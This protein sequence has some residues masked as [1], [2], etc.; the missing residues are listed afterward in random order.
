[1]GHGLLV[2]FRKRN[3]TTN[4]QQSRFRDSL[5]KLSAEQR[6]ELV[7]EKDEELNTCV[8]YSVVGSASRQGISPS[9]LMK[10]RWVVTFKDCGQLRSTLDTAKF[11]GPK[12]WQDHNILSN[13]IPLE[14][15]RFS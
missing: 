2:F 6:R 15:V 12:T 3:T 13:R 8:K 10:M 11:Y 7:E 14:L 1:M 5:Q 9:A 4:L